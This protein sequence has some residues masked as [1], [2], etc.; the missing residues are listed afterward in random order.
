MSKAFTIIEVLVILAVI[1]VLV[2]LLLPSVR[3][4][5]EAARR[6]SCSNNI[7]QIG[8]AIHNYHSAYKQLPKQMDGTFAATHQS[9]S[10]RDHNGYR[11]SFLVGL[12]PFAEQQRLWEEITDGEKSVTMG[13]PPWSNEFKP[14]T[15]EVP[16]WRCPSD[17][18]IGS[19][20][21]A[22]TNFA[23]CL[24]DAIEG[25]Q[26]GAAR[27]DSRLS[28]WVSVDTEQLDATGRGAFVPRKVIAFEDI[29]DGLSNTII[30]AEIATDLGDGDIRTAPLQVEELQVIVDQPNWCKDRRDPDNPSVWNDY[31]DQLEQRFGAL[32][33]RRGL[34][35]ADGAALYTGMN[36]ILPPNREI[37]LSGGDAGIGM[38]ASSS[39]HYGG[40]HV[41][42]GD[43]A[44]IFITDSIDCGDLDSGTVVLH[45]E[46]GRAPGSPSPYGIWGAL[47]TRQSKEVIDE[48]I[49]R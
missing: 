19:P 36:T 13:P 46:D 24:G 9:Q 49:N 35:W 26:H 31:Q 30:G 29:L 21:L 17:P 34:R 41:L 40:T 15:T 39:R 18:G 27:W 8:L 12:L 28:A 5:R 16:T 3:T 23:A 22:R 48:Q 1:G 4:A 14:W 43:G 20:G 37:S 10:D 44:V 47:G 33:R 6:M 45:G 32:D 7:K 25:L 11:L 38:L 2:G 42:M